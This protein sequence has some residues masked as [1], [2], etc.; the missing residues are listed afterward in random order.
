[1]GG[2]WF[3][4]PKRLNGGVLSLMQGHLQKRLESGFK[5][6]SCTASK[7]EVDGSIALPSL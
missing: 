6:I 1:M 3:A 2:F 4:V 5:I 7:I